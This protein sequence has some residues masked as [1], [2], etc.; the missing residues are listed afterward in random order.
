MTEN[1]T[2]KLK[3]RMKC[4]CNRYI[5]CQE[6]REANTGKLDE[7]FIVIDQIDRAIMTRANELLQQYT[8]TKDPDIWSKR[9][10]LA[11]A[12]NILEQFRNPRKL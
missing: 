7:R 9:N 1:K 10:G 2:E 11:E 4:M 5:T 6:C 8:D 12:L 3:S